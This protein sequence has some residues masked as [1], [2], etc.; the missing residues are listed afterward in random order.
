MSRPYGAFAEDQ[1]AQRSFMWLQ[2]DAALAENLL[3]TAESLMA[4]KVFMFITKADS[5]RQIYQSSF[6]TGLCFF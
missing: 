6:L 3:S 1:I 4:G 2:Y 5:V